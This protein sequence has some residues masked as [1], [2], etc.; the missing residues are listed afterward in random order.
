MSADPRVQAV[1]DALAD[2]NWLKNPDATLWG[3]LAE[4][5]VAAIDACDDQRTGVVSIPVERAEKLANWLRGMA[6]WPALAKECKADGRS[7][8]TVRA[9]YNEWADLL[10]PAGAS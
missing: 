9:A 1:A 2:H 7:L 10:D 4:V 3:N 8:A 6:D 5:A